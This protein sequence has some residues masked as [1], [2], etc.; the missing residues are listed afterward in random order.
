MRSLNPSRVYS[1]TFLLIIHRAGYTICMEILKTTGEQELF[2]EKK[3]LQSM[4]SAGIEYSLAQEV[5]RMVE[6]DKHNLRSTD[7]LH[8][9]TE[10]SLV[11]KANLAAAARYNLKRSIIDLGP[12]GY[13]FEQY[14]A[15][16][17]QAYGY[18]TQ[19]NQILPGKCV[20]HEIDVIARRD[21]LHYMIECKH[22]QYS[23]AKTKIQVALYT[24]ARFQDIVE[25]WAV[26]EGSRTD[27]HVPWLVT[28]TKVTAD[29]ITYA[30]CVGMKI[31][32]WHYPE[33]QGLNEFIEKNKLYPVTVLP[34]MSAKNQQTLVRT[35]LIL[36]SDIAALT[37]KQLRDK[38]KFSPAVISKI[39]ETASQLLG[40]A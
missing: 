39:F 12:S 28:N 21:D 6:R 22:H 9:A 8:S 20:Q 29:V 31:L 32:A 17:F 11:K 25:R 14:I 38:T 16:L 35:N 24:Y 5:M 2:K 33:R 7:S 40:T 30:N 34:N 4:R 3:Y 18:S 10:R 37:P 26:Q 15:R 19:T 36:L 23:G 27:Q 13:P 1:S